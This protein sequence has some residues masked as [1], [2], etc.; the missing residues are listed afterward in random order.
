MS[1]YFRANMREAISDLAGGFANWRVWYL[2]G[3][4]EVRHRY[5]RSTIGPF[6]LTL[7]M[8][9]QAT[10]MGVLFGFLFQQNLDRFLPF[11]CI[12]LVLWNFI[13]SVV[14]DGAMS[15]IGASGLIMQVKRPL[16]V[17]VFQVVWRNVIILGHT[18]V[19]FFLVAVIFSVYPTWSYILALPGLALMLLNVSW[20]ALAAA[21]LSARFRDVPM[22]IQ[23][24]FTVL[25]WLTPVLYL[26]SQ[27]KGKMQIVVQVNPLAHILEVVRA[28]LLQGVPTTTNWLVAAGVALVGWALVLLLFA[29]TRSRVPHWL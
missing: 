25:F 10:V 26:P 22:I 11:L 7:S 13:Q 14:S 20:T 16:C 4:N 3:L 17:H 9:V 5:R 24:A 28:P 19:I 21:I 8:G 1:L 27:M 18:V 23:N 12:S 15:F 29:R 2:L 6:W